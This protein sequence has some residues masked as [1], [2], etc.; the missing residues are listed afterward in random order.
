MDT[1]YL[2]GAFV[3]AR[4]ARVSV[5]DRGY[6]FADG[7]YEVLF[8]WG[9]RYAFL[10]KHL[11]RLERSAREL[12]MDLPGGAAGIRKA[13]EELLRRDGRQT[14]AIYIQVTRGTAPRDHG[15]PSPD[16]S[17]TVVMYL[18]EAP[19]P[20]PQMTRPT[21]VVTVPDL[22]WLRCDIKTVGLLA[23]VLARQEALERGAKDAVLVRD[24]V[25]TEGASSNLFAVKKGVLHTHPEGHLILSGI[26]REVVLEEASRL[27]IPVCEE[28]IL[29]QELF[30][31]DELFA[32]GTTT[33]VQAIGEVDGC[34]VGT[35]ADG[36]VTSAMRQAYLRRL[37]EDTGGPLVDL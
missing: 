14:G 27:G 2:N 33:H 16:T 9:G 8:V 18:K 7:I 28:P 19:A 30:T 1:V 36:A 24:G 5:E 37:A 29:A 4:E 23:N 21:A 6:Q 13:M 17:P 25:V 12:H 26:T 3:P 20:G 11:R 31:V 35:G 32:T 22:R 15:F 34:T 10:D